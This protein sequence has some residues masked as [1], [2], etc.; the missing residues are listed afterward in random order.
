MVLSSALIEFTITQNINR[1]KNDAGK[2]KRKFFISI[3]CSVLTASKE[4]LIEANKQVVKHW[5]KYAND[6]ESL[7]HDNCA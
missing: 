4:S 7:L 3:H 2:P 5:Y 6:I 1:N